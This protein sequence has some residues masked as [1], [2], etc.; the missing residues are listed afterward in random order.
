MPYWGGNMA[1]F[2]INYLAVLISAVASFATGML[3][4]SRV[5][6][7]NLWMKFSG[8]SKTSI[9]KSKKK[10]MA[11]YLAAAFIGGL[12]MSFV[13]AHFVDIAGAVTAL[14]GAQTGFWSWLGFVAPVM[15]GTVLWEGKSFKLYLINASHYLVVLMAMGSILAV[16][17]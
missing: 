3:W 17:V 16:W 8:I 13:L 4:Y 1:T 10:G 6:F 14:E 2:D 5:L 9:E 12:V 7:G 11:P 15:L